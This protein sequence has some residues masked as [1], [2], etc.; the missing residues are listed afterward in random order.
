M[1]SE[2]LVMETFPPDTMEV[3]LRFSSAPVVPTVP[4]MTPVPALFFMRNHPAVPVAEAT[5]EATVLR[6]PL[7]LLN[8]A[9]AVAGKA[10]VAS[11]VPV[12][13]VPGSVG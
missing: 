8:A 1:L 3:V 12:A 4:S 9:N 6:L 11:T 7:P 10:K 2:P 13:A 5:T